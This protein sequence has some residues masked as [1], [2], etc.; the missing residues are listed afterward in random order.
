V[1]GD[2]LFSAALRV[3]HDLDVSPQMHR[4]Q[5]RIFSRI[6]C[7]TGFGQAID[8]CQSHVPIS[9]VPE[10]LLLREYHWKTASYTF[11]GPMVS[12]A[13][14]A[15]VEGEAQC[16]IARFALALG[17]AYQLQNDLIDLANDVHEGCDIV[18]GKRTVTMIRAR[19]AMDESNRAGFD[20]KLAELKGANGQ[21]MTIARQ[22]RRELRDAGAVDRTRELIGSFLT[23][24]RSAAVSRMVPAS[25]RDGMVE[26][27]ESLKS[28]YFDATV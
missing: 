9:D 4:D 17:Q 3:L 22:L 28:E 15:G 27:L 26:V 10:A 11:E 25:M 2:L 24:A 12:G 8:I 13:I 1:A 6:A 20:R 14:L 16:E 18:Q 23:E 19:A 5:L 21:T 7:T